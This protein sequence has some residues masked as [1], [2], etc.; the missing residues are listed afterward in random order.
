MLGAISLEAY[1]QVPSDGAQ[2]KVVIDTMKLDGA[3]HLPDAVRAQL[4]SSFQ[5]REFDDLVP[6]KRVSEPVS[7]S[8][9]Q[10][11]EGAYHDS[12]AADDE[13]YWKRTQR[14]EWKILSQDSSTTHVAVTVSVD[15]GR[16][17]RLAGIEF[18]SS[19]RNPDTEIFQP[20]KMR[21]LIPMEDGQFFSTSKVRQGLDALRRLYNFHGYV[22][23]A[24]LP[25]IKIDEEQRLVS[26]G[27]ELDQGAQYRVGSVQVFGLAPDLE[28]LL[29][30]TIRVGDIY[31]L[32]LIEDFFGDYGPVLPANSSLENTLQCQA[33]SQRR[34][35]HLIFDFRPESRSSRELVSGDGCEVLVL[36]SRRSAGYPA[37]MRAHLPA[38]RTKVQ[39]HCPK[40]SVAHVRL[41]F[42]AANFLWDE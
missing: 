33:D 7:D 31:N 36:P 26:L 19:N 13:G 30:Q 2:S 38:S 15:E 25:D 32:S 23:F 12:P 24:V 3:D 6:G 11:I 18:R 4:E 8:V 37:T 39:F 20:D 40:I 5:G 27:I 17:Y 34:L 29:T 9:S 35:L 41:A 14:V 1:A 42:A 22:D 28:S 16:Q 21:K 10:A